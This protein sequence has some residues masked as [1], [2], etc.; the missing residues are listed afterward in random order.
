[1]LEPALNTETETLEH[2]RDDEVALNH[3]LDEARGLAA[4]VVERGRAEAARFREEAR[5]SIET[6][7]LRVRAEEARATEAALAGHRSETARL[8]AGLR[9]QA[10]KNRERAIRILLDVLAGRAP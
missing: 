9:D 6:E 2:L 5:P 1:M 4:Q 3:K 7:R 10:N 8:I